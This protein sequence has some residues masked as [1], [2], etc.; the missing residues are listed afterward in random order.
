MK[1]WLLLT[2]IS[3]FALVLAACGGGDSGAEI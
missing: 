3:A 1:K 2:I